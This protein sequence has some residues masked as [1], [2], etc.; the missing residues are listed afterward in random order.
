M[1]HHFLLLTYLSKTANTTL[2]HR[3]CRMMSAIDFL[4]VREN[5]AGSTAIGR[6]VIGIIGLL[7]VFERELTGERVKAS[8]IARAR[9]E[10]R[11]AG[12]PLFTDI[13]SSMTA[14]QDG[15]K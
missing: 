15:R 9:Q 11:V 7:S 1:I 10:M 14:K 5:L 3:S 2:G 4:S 13:S 12:R 8:Q 6:V